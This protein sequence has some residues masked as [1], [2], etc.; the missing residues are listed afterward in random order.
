MGK[1]EWG[2]GRA[3]RLAA[4]LAPLACVVATLVPASAAAS[5]PPFLEPTGSLVAG[6]GGPVAAALPSGEVLVAGGYVYNSKLDYQGHASKLAEVYDPTTG[7]FTAATGEMTQ[8]RYRSAGAL[9]GSGEVL[10]AGGLTGGEFS[11]VTATA[12][13]FDP[14]TGQFTATTP[15]PGEE[16]A[17]WDDFAVSLPNGF[18]MVGGGSMQVT[19]G[20]TKRLASTEV[21]DPVPEFVGGFHREVHFHSGPTMETARGRAAAALLPDG[22]VLIAGG[23]NASFEPLSSTEIYDPE[24]ETITP[25]PAMAVADYGSA[26]TLADG[27]VL[28]LGTTSLQEYDPATNSFA[29]TGL[30][31]VASLQGAGLAPLPE[32]RALLAGRNSA[33][34]SPVEHEASIFVSAPQPISSGLDFGTVP[35]AE[36]SPPEALTVVNRGAQALEVEAAVLTGADAADFE[37]VK[38]GCTGQTLAYGEECELKITVTPPAPGALSAAVELTDNSPTSPQLLPLTAAGS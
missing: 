21:F 33:E 4:W 23:Y 18:V 37:I 25:G 7:T 31:G 16:G 9:L 6:H 14:V 5:T 32:G 2:H 3:R 19:G 15:I 38:D 8:R 20:G 11:A 10:I 22:D 1:T 28:F 13:L 35:S 24:T 30:T 36:T 29:P 27:H 12:E 17:R 26:V 34:F